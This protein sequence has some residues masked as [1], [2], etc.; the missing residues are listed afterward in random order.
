[1]GGYNLDAIA[2]SAAAC[3]RVLL[4][5]APAQTDF[6]KPSPIAARVLDEVIRTQEPFWPG[7]FSARG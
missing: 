1:V 2:A 4:G 3:L 5:E 6:G 7:A